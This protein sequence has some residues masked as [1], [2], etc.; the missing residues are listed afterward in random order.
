[1]G[2]NNVR[3]ITKV[4]KDDNDNITH[5]GGSGFMDPIATAIY[6]IESGKVDYTTGSVTNPNVHVVHGKT[7]DYLRTNADGTSLN[8][9][10]NK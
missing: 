4:Q 2:K 6:N 5:V 1:M 3:K 10:D 9:L 7:K 8:N